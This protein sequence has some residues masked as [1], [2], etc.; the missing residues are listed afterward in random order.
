MSQDPRDFLP[1]PQAD[2]AAPGVLPADSSPGG[3]GPEVLQDVG[4]GV[5]AW[6]EAA[7]GVSP[8]TQIKILLSVLAVV[9]VY[10]MKRV[11]MRVVEG[12]VDDPKL[13]YQWSKTSSY[14]AFFLTFLMVGT[15]WIEGVR[16][17]STFLGLLSAGLA[18]A[19]KDLVASLAGWIFILWRRPF[20]LGDRIQLAG[21]AG[22]VVDIRIFQ[23]TIL[24]IGNWV[25]A[26]QSTGRIIHIP[27]ARLFTD[28]L[29]NFTSQ[30]E[31]IWNEIPIL[32]T[33]ESD[34]RKAKGILR[35]IIDEIVGESVQE[36]QR[37]MRAV[38]KKFLIYF[39]NLTPIVYTTVKDSGVLLTVRFL[40]WARQRRGMTEAVWEAVLDAFAEEERIELAYPTTRM[41]HNLLEG[42]P[43]ARAEL[44]RTGLGATAGEP[45]GDPPAPPD[46]R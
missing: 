29:A 12:R 8:G 10:A 19:L 41:Y 5:S 2:S 18:I 24:E 9:L 17:L 44:P 43:G 6:I 16:H 21:H 37:A 26:D 32:L 31:F 22:D 34:W 14:L 20:Q 35:G 33:F 3:R 39:P 13:L 38:S 46:P 27:N 4:T 45:G 25:D 30:F 15:V 7:T 40:C 1:G 36:A 42:K 23:F 28:S 11:V